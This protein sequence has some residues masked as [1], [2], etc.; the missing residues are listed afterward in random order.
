MK[1]WLVLLFLFLVTPLF[2]ES[3][4]L[5]LDGALPDQ[6]LVHW[7]AVKGADYYDIYLDQKPVKR[8]EQTQ[9]VLA[10]LHSHTSYEVL[11]AA[12][13]TGNVDI[14]ADAAHF[15]TTGWEGWYRWVNKTKTDNNGKCRQLDF[16]VVHTA[17]GYEIHGLYDRLY[18]L[19]PV[20][21]C[22]QEFPYE[23]ESEHQTA[24]RVNAEM[25]NTTKVTPKT[26]MVKEVEIS[27][28]S[29]R[30]VMQTK[31]GALRFTT[32]SCYRFQVSPTGEKELCFETKGEGMA[33]WGVFKSPNPEDDG[34]F[35]C[36]Y[37]GPAQSVSL[38]GIR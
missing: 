27:D 16:L 24:Y 22:E 15:R 7:D 28:S 32:T 21:P 20:A 34:V 36:S 23:G 6:L 14:E 38:Q 1:R 3:M 9:V 2:S 35:R 33:G 11:V 29:L 18:R 25:F 26:W 37:V 31:V 19:F 12:R 4:H 5:E 8:V 17:G 13:K 30:I 10:N